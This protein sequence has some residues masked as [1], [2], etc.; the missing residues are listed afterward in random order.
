M[1]HMA[2]LAPS[3]NE[4]RTQESRCRRRE[5]RRNRSV[6]EVGLRFDETVPVEVIEVRDP[7][8]VSIPESVRRLLLTVMADCS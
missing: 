4:V 2:I 7:A 1:P 5:K 3:E 6:N 8:I